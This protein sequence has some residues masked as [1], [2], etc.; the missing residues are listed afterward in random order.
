MS[1]E[2]IPFSNASPVNQYK[3]KCC[4]V[5]YD[6][7]AVLDKKKTLQ[8]PKCGNTSPGLAITLSV[9]KFTDREIEIVKRLS[10]YIMSKD[11]GS[12]RCLIYGILDGAEYSRGMEA[13]LLDLNNWLFDQVE[14]SEEEDAAEQKEIDQEQEANI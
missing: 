4:D 2:R 14:I 9:Y 5:E 3:T 6:M 1:E 10:A 11:Y 8:C 12:Y 13:G 7:E